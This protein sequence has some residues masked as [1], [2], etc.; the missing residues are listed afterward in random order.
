[1]P[2]DREHS[3]TGAYPKQLNEIVAID[4][5]EDS[6]VGRFQQQNG[7]EFLFAIPLLQQL[8]SPTTTQ[9]LVRMKRK[10]RRLSAIHCTIINII[11]TDN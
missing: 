4:E 6:G 11:F 7:A 10:K 1:M 5:A 3:E 2:L 9:Y 8:M